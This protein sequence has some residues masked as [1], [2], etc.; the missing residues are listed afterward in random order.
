MTTL[1]TRAQ[2]PREKKIVIW[3]VG[4]DVFDREV[5]FLISLMNPD[6]AY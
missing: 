1:S 2:A 3:A 5:G 6:L 4:G